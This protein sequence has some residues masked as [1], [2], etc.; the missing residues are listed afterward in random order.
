[1][2]ITVLTSA[3]GFDGVMPKRFRS[4]LG[5]KVTRVYSSPQEFFVIFAL[6]HLRSKR[7]FVPAPVR[8]NDPECARVDR[9]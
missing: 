8:C 9:V 7:V 5:V 2:Y 6:P 1:M 4:E 3:R